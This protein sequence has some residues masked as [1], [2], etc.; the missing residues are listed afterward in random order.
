VDI[1]SARGSTEPQGGSR[2]LKPIGA[3]IA[4]RLPVRVSYT[5]LVYPATFEHFEAGY[6]ARFDL[7]ESPAEGVAALVGLLN[8]SCKECPERRYVLL[9]YSQ[10]AQVVGDAL[11]RPEERLAGRVAGEVS[12][13]ASER[14]T[15]VVLFGNPRF[16]AGEPFNAG[17][18]E[19]GV[20]GV[21]PRRKGALAAYA[22]RL[23]DYCA[24][25]D[26]ASQSTPGANVQ[27]HVAYFTNPMPRD[28]A[29]FAV[30]KASAELAGAGCM[31]LLGTAADG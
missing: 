27:A 12:P 3:A 18:F 1:V 16:T 4:A 13:E 5:E 23:R 2:L 25:G 19:P 26:L 21:S 11:V 24:A 10:G 7:G 30:R 6:P 31:N 15:A 29:A 17:T 20:E 8:R 9:G 22:D 14:I 28:G